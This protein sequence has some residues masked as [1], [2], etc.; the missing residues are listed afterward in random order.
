MSLFK[1]R[2]EKAKAKYEV[3]FIVMHSTLAWNKNSSSIHARYVIK[4][5]PVYLSRSYDKVVEWINSRRDDYYIAYVNGW[6][7]E[8]KDLPGSTDE[9]C[10]SR[11]WIVEQ[12]LEN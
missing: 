3:I 10:F 12:I 9:K 8:E 5:E 4:P 11:M 7:T 6:A 2:K 1:K